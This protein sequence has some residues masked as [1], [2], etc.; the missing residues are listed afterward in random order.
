MR[1]GTITCRFSGLYELLFSHIPENLQHL[2]RIRAAWARLSRAWAAVAR[3][4][5]VLA[6]TGECGERVRK[7]CANP[8][9]RVALT[10]QKWQ[11]RANAGQTRIRPL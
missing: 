10:V 9:I 7:R 2:G 8:T 1:I 5:R 4:A 11:T 3:A 6:A